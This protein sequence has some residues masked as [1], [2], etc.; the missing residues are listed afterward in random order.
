M[1]PEVPAVLV[2]PVVPEVPVVPAVLGANKWELVTVVVGPAMLDQVLTTPQ[3]NMLPNPLTIPHK[4]KI[5][6]GIWGYLKDSLVV[7][8]REVPVPPK[9]GQLETLSRPFKT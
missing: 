9:E 5:P 1:V 2:V 8:D 7:P 6:P 4:C 3:G